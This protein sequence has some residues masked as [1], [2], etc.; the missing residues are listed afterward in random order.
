MW[1]QM[2]CCNIKT[3]NTWLLVFIYLLIYVFIFPYLG[4]QN[5]MAHNT[6]VVSPVLTSPQTT[7]NHLN[8]LCTL[9]TWSRDQL[10]PTMAE[11]RN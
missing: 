7:I 6:A 11:I 2:H 9:P 10:L 4:N 8:A 1:K 5:S 3:I